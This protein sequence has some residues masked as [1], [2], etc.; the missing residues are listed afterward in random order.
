M[1][2]LN[3]PQSFMGSSGRIPWEYRADV[4]SRTVERFLARL[5]GGWL[6]ELVLR[7]AAGYYG[8]PR[9]GYI[10]DQDIVKD[11]ELRIEG[12]A[13]VVARDPKD[14]DKIAD[15]A[16][17]QLE[18]RIRGGLL[19]R[20]AWNLFL[21][22]WRKMKRE[23]KREA[24]FEMAERAAEN[25]RRNAQRGEEEPIPDAEKYERLRLTFGP[26]A[27]SPA[28]EMV[29]FAWG[30]GRTPQAMVEDL[31]TLTVAQ[32]A[33][34]W[35][36][37]FAEAEHHDP[38]AVESL[39]QGMKD[40]AGSEKLCEFWDP[41]AAV[42]GWVAQV[43]S[44]IAAGARTPKSPLHKRV[45]YL[46]RRKLPYTTERI[47]AQLGLWRLDRLTAEFVPRYAKYAGRDP[48]A[49][50]AE[51][52]VFLAHT[53]AP[54]K[55]LAYLYKPHDHVEDW[56]YNVRRR[57]AAA[58]LAQLKRGLR[59]VVSG[60]LEPWRAM[61]FLLCH[62]LGKTP[63]F[64]ADKYGSQALKSMRDGLVHD[65]ARRWDADPGDVRAAIAPLSRDL[66]KPGTPPTLEA[67]PRQDD[68]LVGQLPAWRDEVLAVVGPKF[69][70]APD[71]KLF[72]LRHRLPHGAGS[73]KGAS[74]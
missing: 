71:L 69:A 53:N 10:L 49:V 16:R 11:V 14:A 6:F 47:V 56:Q 4:E 45:A 50:D 72:A 64:V 73:P 58:E 38:A 65:F 63:H 74:A 29:A 44:Q 31:A 42:D 33:D 25:S 60:R 62:C 21:D 61:A 48:K 28:H 26:K 23:R 32:L 27:T 41:R 22:M 19:S 46:Y 35:I 17:Q 12:L 34:S 24:G 15:L 55:P 13:R 43:Q 51:F 36:Q 7:A 30:P 59:I 2:P 68:D 9:D 39:F 54:D 57:A 67:C 52:K 40:T 66:I 37:C 1:N 3:D 18:S 20:M 8:V 70:V 5:R